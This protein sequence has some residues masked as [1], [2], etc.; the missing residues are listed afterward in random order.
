MY[1]ICG[2]LHCARITMLYLMCAASLSLINVAS[3]RNS[4]YCST[5]NYD[6]CA[7]FLSKTLRRK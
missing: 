1:W 6:N 7:L 3:D 5:D 4:G 2:N